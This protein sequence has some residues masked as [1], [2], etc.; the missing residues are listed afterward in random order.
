[1]ADSY[2]EPDLRE[3]V[4]ELEAELNK[5][6]E[7]NAALKKKRR[8]AWLS[9]IGRAIASAWLG[10]W[11]WFWDWPALVLG[12]LGALGLLV[13][14]LMKADEGH[15]PHAEA[16]IDTNGKPAFVL[17]CDQSG[18][19]CAVL[20]GHSCPHGY[21]VTKEMQDGILIVCKEEKK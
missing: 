18:S 17:H 1:M 19:S 15:K 2:R 3:R 12:S 16:T 20:A 13:F 8:W 6:R 11:G 10:F 14:M 21:D 7:E 5:L 9:A 4:C